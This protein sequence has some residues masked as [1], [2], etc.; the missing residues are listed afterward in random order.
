MRFAELPPAAVMTLEQEEL[1]AFRSAAHSLRIKYEGVALDDPHLL[2]DVEIAAGTLPYRLLRR[3][4]DFRLRSDPAGTLLLRGLPVDPLPPTPADGRSGEW[5][6]LPLTTLAQLAVMSV[7]GDVVSYADE[8]S[9]RLVQDVCP[10]PGAESRRENTGSV[11]LELHTEDGFHPHKPA[12]LSLYC[13][14]DDH[15]R[16][17]ATVTASA[18]AVLDTL[19]PEVLEVLHSPRFRIRFASSFGAG[20]PRY[21]APLPVFTGPVANPELTVDFHAME[22]LDADACAA[23]AA[24][25]VAMENALVGTVLAPGDLIVVNNRAAVHGRTG[26]RPR[27]DGTDRW[28][29][30]CFAVPDLWESRG[31]RA[32]ESR[33]CAPLGRVLV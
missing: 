3:L 13:L 1:A 32:A 2:A 19:P 14:R 15:D 4:I 25:R 12:L 10:V 20:P 18:L 26:F 27:H 24:L 5:W 22:G 16:T 31:V 21:C 30:R 17:A 29:R 11:L 23:L 9:G 28:L 7:L 8:K 33:V 6:T